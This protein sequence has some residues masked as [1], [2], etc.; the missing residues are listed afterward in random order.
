MPIN[1]RNGW[2]KNTT[3]VQAIAEIRSRH[4]SSSAEQRP[5]NARVE[6][7]NIGGAVMWTLAVDARWLIETA[8]SGS[9]TVRLGDIDNYRVHDIH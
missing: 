4:R 2:R 3:I 8:G 9:H 1:C 6:K 5:Q 7:I